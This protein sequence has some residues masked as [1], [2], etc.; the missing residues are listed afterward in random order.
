MQKAVDNL[1]PKEQQSILNN[2]IS[3]KYEKGIDYTLVWEILFILL[4]V[5]IFFA[6]K[7]YLL[8]KSIKETE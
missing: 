7:Q 8:R 6:Y 5:I 2:W 1:E 3:I 4:A